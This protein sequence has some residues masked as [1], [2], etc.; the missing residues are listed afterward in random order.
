MPDSAID[1]T[2]IDYILRT[3]RSVRKRM[4]LNRPIPLE[5]IEECLELA[6]Q[7]P[8]GANAQTWRFIVVTDPGQRQRIA[9]VYRRGVEQYVTGKTGLD[10][11]GVSPSRQFPEGDVRSQQVP[12][13]IESG[14]YLSEHLAEVPV[15]IVTCLEG[16]VDDDDNFTRTSF[17]GSI[18]PATWSLMLAL[19]SRGL[20]SSLTT[21]SLVFE[22]DSA[23]VLGI[24]DG[25]TQ[26]AL[27]PVAYPDN[28]SF[29][30]AK[31]LPA[32]AVTYLNRWGEEFTTT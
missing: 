7:A 11:V 1:L 21:L 25:V 9:E 27:L 17:Y 3:T 19:R 8:T 31:R 6:L 22:D 26:A 5:L 16:R 32:R 2:N 15:H 28:P 24:P 14:A 23:N 12:A 20:V 29:R 18:L 13:N 10:R 30:Q 4:D